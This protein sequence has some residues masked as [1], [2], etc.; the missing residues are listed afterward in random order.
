MSPSISR[1]SAIELGPGDVLVLR[2]EHDGQLQQ[3]AALVDLV[4][5][6]A[7]D[8]GAAAVH[9]P[10]SNENEAFTANCDGLAG[11]GESF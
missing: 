3:L 1:A 10:L 11:E 6:H 2:V 5:G 9:E 7:L 4:H 8:H